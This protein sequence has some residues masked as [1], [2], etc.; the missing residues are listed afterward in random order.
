MAQRHL[1][2]DHLLAVEDAVR[3]I[4]EDDHADV[5]GR[6]PGVGQHRRRGLL[7]QGA[8][9]ATVV[10]AERR[11]GRPEHLDVH[12]RTIRVWPA[13]YGARTAFLS[14]LP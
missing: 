4:A 8:E 14:G 6:Q 5:G 3:R 9:V 10:A 11:H 13:Q 1:T 12:H 7:G 2:P